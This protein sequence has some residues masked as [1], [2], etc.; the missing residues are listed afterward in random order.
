METSIWTDIWIWKQLFMMTMSSSRIWDGFQTRFWS[1]FLILLFS[2]ASSISLI[3]DWSITCYFS[4]RYVLMKT[5]YTV[6][7]FLTFTDTRSMLTLLILWFPMEL[8]NVN[9]RP[10]S[11]LILQVQWRALL[12]SYCR[13]FTWLFFPGQLLFITRGTS[14]TRKTSSLRHFMSRRSRRKKIWKELKMD[15]YGKI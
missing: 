4:N 5:M 2:F 9:D 15:Y 3:E 11:L 14:S 10:L 7:F 6:A 13:P 1:V 12:I 8:R